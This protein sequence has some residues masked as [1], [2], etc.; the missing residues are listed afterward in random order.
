MNSGSWSYLSL[1]RK[2]FQ[3]L[4][5]TDFAFN[6]ISWLN[7]SCR[8]LFKV[9]LNKGELLLILKNKMEIWFNGTKIFD[10]LGDIDS[11]TI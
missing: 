4:F 3:V 2:F 5:Q 11:A 9:H 10:F 1:S 6:L 7:E 8:R